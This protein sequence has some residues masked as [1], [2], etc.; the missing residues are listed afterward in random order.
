MINFVIVLIFWSSASYC[1][2]IMDGRPSKYCSTCIVVA[3][4]LLGWLTYMITLIFLLWEFMFAMC[5]RV[6]CKIELMSRDLIFFCL[7]K[8]NHEMH[9][10]YFPYEIERKVFLHKWKWIIQFW[11][12]VF[13]TIDM[14]LHVLLTL[15]LSPNPLMKCH[16]PSKP[17]MMARTSLLLGSCGHHH[18]GHLRVSH[19]DCQRRQW[20][21]W[22]PP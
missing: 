15:R 12:R 1:E 18:G 8:A 11:S 4:Q 6:A 16:I 14:T 13:T 19:E 9:G 21:L 7:H 10:K 17:I 3:V 2:V 22:Q 20:W 5:H